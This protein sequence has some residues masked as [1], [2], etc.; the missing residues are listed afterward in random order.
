MAVPSLISLHGFIVFSFVFLGCSGLSFH[1]KLLTAT[2][3]LL[4][5]E[6]KI[7]RRVNEYRAAH[8]LRR[9]TQDPLISQQARNHSK[10]MANKNIV[11]SHSGFEERVREIAKKI[12]YRSAGENI[13]VNQGYDDPVAV[14]FRGWL[15]SPTHKKTIEENFN[16]TGVG[17]GKD[18]DGTYYF[19]QIFILT[20]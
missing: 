17:V 12:P 9:L 2:P 7:H 6:Q 14:A 15:E 5:L 16:L 4:E 19:T 11:V 1:Q 8:N 10:A 3:E 20:K 13:A 18:R